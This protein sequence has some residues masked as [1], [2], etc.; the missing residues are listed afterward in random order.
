VDELLHVSVNSDTW[1]PHEIC[2][3]QGS[4]PG[5]MV[6]SNVVF[7]PE[8]TAEELASLPKAKEVRM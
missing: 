6:I 1:F 5:T 8:L 3:V 7:D 2:V 4:S